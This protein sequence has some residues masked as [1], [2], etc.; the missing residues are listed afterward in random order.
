MSTAE[1]AADTER[2]SSDTPATVSAAAT[3]LPA[4]AVPLT[5]FSP[6]HQ[7]PTSTST[8]HHHYSQTQALLSFHSCY[9][10]LNFVCKL[11]ELMTLE[12]V[13]KE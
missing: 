8:A 4:S 11:A 2:D 1:V 7:Q 10:F 12:M 6:R 13:Y 9:F 3:G 5:C